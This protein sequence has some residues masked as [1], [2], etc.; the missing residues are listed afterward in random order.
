MTFSQQSE[1]SLQ[2]FIDL[3][4]ELT[5]P[6]GKKVKKSPKKT[7]GISSETKTQGTKELLRALKKDIEAIPKDSAGKVKA[8]DNIFRKHN[9]KVP[10]QHNFGRSAALQYVKALMKA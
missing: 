4:P 5:Q 7:P 8:V 1:W 6:D 10:E 2:D 9:V 3:L